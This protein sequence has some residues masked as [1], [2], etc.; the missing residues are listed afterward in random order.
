MSIERSEVASR[1]DLK[2]LID[3]SMQSLFVSEEPK[4]L[5]DPCRY[6]A[7]SGGKRIR[8]VLT[9]LTSQM[10][11]VEVGYALNAALAVELFHNFTLVHD[12]IMDEADARR[13]RPSVHAKW[14]EATAILAGD[15]M[16]ARSY[17]TL[18]S[19]YPNH[20]GKLFSAFSRT[21]VQLC[22][23]Q[24]LDSEFESRDHVALDDYMYMISLKTGALLAF[25]FEVGG[26]LADAT[27]DQLADLRQIGIELGYAFQIQDDVL[28]LFADDPKWGKTLGGDLVQGK[29]TYLVLKANS[30]ATNPEDS[31]RL[32]MYLGGRKARVSEV[33][34]FKRMLSDIGIPGLARTDIDA[35][36][37]SA[38]SLL[39]RFPN[40]D[41]RESII[42]IIESMRIRGV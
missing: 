3:D 11:G 23:G 41:A 13:G 30:I 34:G 19:N 27:A 7:T 36:S 26:I 35:H 6:A 31:E 18:L 40:T 33:G 20:V 22:E 37:A 21:V 5:Y 17:E 4:S 12:D 1:S 25:V 28:D 38:L 15:L 2:R 8:P 10:L 39:K 29:R 9:L 16:L 42:D 32:S 14:D 24:A